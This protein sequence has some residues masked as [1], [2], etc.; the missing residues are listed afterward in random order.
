LERK[1]Q[2]SGWDI[3]LISFSDP[4]D[5]LGKLSKSR[6]SG[7]SGTND[8]KRMLPLTIDQRD[9][10]GLS[11]TNAE[12][13][14]YLLQ[15]RNRRYVLAA[16]LSGRR[17][18]ENELLQEL[19]KLEIRVLVDAGAQ[20]LEMTNRGLVKAWLDISQRA[21]AA[22]YFDEK[23][24]SYVLYRQGNL[25]PLLAS[26]FA[27]NLGECLVYLDEA[28]TRGTDLKF[29]ADAC[30]ALTLGLGQTKDHTVQGS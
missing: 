28:H 5:K 26:P 18:S 29:P 7:F 11:H 23:N 4:D 8:L 16:D 19:T 12:V 22:I 15:P 6:T 9:L 20:I 3:P 17:L 30:A 27:E 10:P 1:L 14:T 24:Q 2:A 21:P 25:I 13:L